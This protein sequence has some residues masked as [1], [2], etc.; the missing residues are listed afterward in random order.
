ML[1]AS[2]FELILVTGQRS[3]G[4]LR[5]SASDATSYSTRRVL[6]VFDVAH[7]NLYQYRI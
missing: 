2:E 1:E 6:Q 7:D 4:A 3:L 5:Q